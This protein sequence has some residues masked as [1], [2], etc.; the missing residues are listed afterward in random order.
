M[1]GFTLAKGDLLFFIP[2]DR[3][4]MPDQLPVCLEMMANADYVC[5]NRVKRADPWYRRIVSKGYNASVRVL[6]HL[7]VHDVNS[8]ILVR[9]AVIER[10]GSH[11]NASST[12]IAVELVIR[13]M[14]ADFRI[15]E[16]PIEHHPRVAGKAR[17][18]R[19]KDIVKIP[20]NLV[21]LW[22][23]LIRLRATLRRE[24]QQEKA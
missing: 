11:I 3:Q 14:Y 1:K 17:G 16:A 4:I 15:A 7:P 13:A 23:Y 18:L 22:I 5:T 24:S 2:S 19:P 12:F 9:R 6:F 10:I 21:V 8:S 20:L